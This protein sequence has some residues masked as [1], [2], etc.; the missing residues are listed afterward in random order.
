MMQLLVSSG[1]RSEALVQYKA[2]RQLLRDELAVEP[3]ATT[4]ALYDKI[5]AG[6]CELNH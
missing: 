5:R 2:C 3:S 1:R 4:R 6:Q